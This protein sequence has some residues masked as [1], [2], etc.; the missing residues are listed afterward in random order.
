MFIFTA[1]D[2]FNLALISVA[3]VAAVVWW[4]VTTIKQATCSHPKTYENR[5]CDAVCQ[6]CGKNLGFIGA[7]REAQAKSKKEKLP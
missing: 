6:Q 3:L 1:Y 7:W 2:V 5:G 4:I